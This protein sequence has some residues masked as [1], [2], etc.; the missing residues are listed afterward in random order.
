VIGFLLVAHAINESAFYELS[1]LILE[2]DFTRA[3]AARA[4]GLGSRGHHLA[5]LSTYLF[6]VVKGHTRKLLAN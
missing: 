6:H 2:G 4:L 5:F 3:I 1:L